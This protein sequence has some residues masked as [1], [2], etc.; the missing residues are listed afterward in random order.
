MAAKKKNIAGS[1]SIEAVTHEEDKRKNIPTLEHRSF[2][3][4]ELK[5]PVQVAYTRRNPD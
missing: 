5:T 1:K 2:M 4:D 3:Y